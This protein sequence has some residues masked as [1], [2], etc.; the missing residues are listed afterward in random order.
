MAER[1]HYCGHITENLVGQTVTV[2]GWVAKRRDLGGLIFFD[3]RDRE[4]IVQCIVNNDNQR[5]FQIGDKIRGEYVVEVTGKVVKRENPNPDLK[6]GNVEIVVKEI[7]ILNT[8]LTPPFYITDE[9]EADAN[10]RLK[11]RYLDLRR[12]KMLKNLMVRSKTTKVVRDYLDSHGFVDVETPILFKSTPEGARDYIVPSRVNPGTFYALP[13]SPQLLKQLLMVS[14]L[15]RY[16]Q[17][18]RCFRDEDLRADRQPEFTQIDIEVSFLERNTFFSIIEG[19]VKEVFSKIKGI[20]I[21]TPFKHMDYNEAMNKYGSDKPDTR[22]GMEI[23]DLSDILK[24]T[25]FKVFSQTIQSGGTVRAIKA[26]G[27]FSRKEID[28]FTDFVKKYGAKGLAWIALKDG[29]IKSPIGK[30]LSEEE[31]K[32]IIEVLQAKDGDTILIVADNVKTTLQSLGALRLHIAKKLDI[33]DKN[34]LNF[35]WI[36][37]FPLLEYDEEEKR[38]IA[39]HHPFTSPLL[40]D[41]HLLD[42]NPEKVRANAYDLVLNGVELAGGSV[43]IHQSEVQQKVFKA[44]GLTEE[45]AKEKFGF[46]LEGLSYGAPPHC[47]IAFGLDRLVMEMV[48]TENIRDVIA[49]P[50]TT[51]ASDLMTDAPSP[52]D[53]KQLEELKISLKLD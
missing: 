43:R 11:Y 20:E 39:A 22:F 29:E 16:Y 46:L 5:V 50:K 15:D 8:A 38:Y 52:V 12:P 14:G 42:T 53:P 47:G 27:E 44:I 40:E 1:T 25:E 3:L 45:M 6:T 34:K 4:G 32:G 19:L 30:F 2:K 18:A 7:T 28:A 51:S 49:F 21:Q 23:H 35:L 48:D 24:S 31:L 9:H 37:N 33:I 36:V 26:Q 13:Q 17:I 41:L 10:L